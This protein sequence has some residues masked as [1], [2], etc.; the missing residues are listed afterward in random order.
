M[1]VIGGCTSH[2]G[3]AHRTLRVIPLPDTARLLAIMK[4]YTAPP[5]CRSERAA[6]TAR[7]SYLMARR[8]AH[9]AHARA[10][11]LA[12]LGWGRG[13]RHRASVSNIFPYSWYFFFF[14]FLLYWFQFLAVTS[15]VGWARLGLT[16]C[17][18][19]VVSKVVLTRLGCLGLQCHTALGDELHWRKATSEL[20]PWELGH[21][22]CGKIRFCR[23]GWKPGT[24]T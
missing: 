8:Q 24:Q 20:G 6:R 10:P 14:F 11:A 19:S 12:R 13:G 5:Q 1:C 21:T 17:H 15:Y 2:A 3:V 18:S 16:S 7:L 4:T 23:N 22:G 9:A